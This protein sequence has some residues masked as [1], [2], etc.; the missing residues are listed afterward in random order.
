M[1]KW[2]R[3]AGV[4]FASY[5][6][7]NVGRPHPATR[8]V[9]PCPR[10]PHQPECHSRILWCEDSDKWS[11]L[12]WD[13]PPPGGS[14][15]HKAPSEGCHSCSRLWS[16]DS[17]SKYP[18]SWTHHQMWGSCPRCRATPEHNT[19]R[20]MKGIEE[21]ESWYDGRLKSDWQPQFEHWAI[22]YVE[23]VLGGQCFPLLYFQG[24]SDFTLKYM[25]VV[26]RSCH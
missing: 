1:I 4:V 24:D 10:T 7:S 26:F 13:P 9:C 20:Q 12:S 3:I 8:A 18:D 23:I 17:H 19:G 16:L 6:Y 2:N 22:Y 21:P 5:H 15:P 25:N 11:C 14:C